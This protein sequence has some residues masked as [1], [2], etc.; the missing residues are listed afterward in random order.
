MY[1]I[2]DIM[3]DIGK[4]Q[5]LV[6]QGAKPL[7]DL[8]EFKEINDDEYLIAV[9]DNYGTDI[10]VIFDTE[11]EYQRW[12]RPEHYNHDGRRP[13]RFLTIHKDIMTNVTTRRTFQ[14]YR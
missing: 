9:I 3:P 14:C 7:S 2:S 6:R 8:P 5:F 4:E 11:Y 1:L 10:V 12:F 13:Y